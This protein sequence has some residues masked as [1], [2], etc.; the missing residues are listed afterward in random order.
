MLEFMAQIPEWLTFLVVGVPLV[1]A[2][3]LVVIGITDKKTRE[4]MAERQAEAE[5]LQES[6]RK[7]YQE[8][9]AAQ[10][11]KIHELTTNIAELTTR[12]NVVEGENRVM[13]AI[14]QGTDPKQAEYR[15]RVEV[16]LT[17]VD[18]LA[19]VIL[20]NGKKSDKILEETLII[21]KNIETLAKAIKKANAN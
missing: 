15:K 4:R 7:L 12:L 13:K 14:L 8:E 6:I 3:G 1:V 21:N 19:D 20:Q 10:N 2:G 17:L 18:K 16:T 5:K 11:E 9:S